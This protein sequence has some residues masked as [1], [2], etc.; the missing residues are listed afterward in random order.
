MSNRVK[1][2]KCQ[3]QDSCKSSLESYQHIQQANICNRIHVSKRKT[4]KLNVAQH[5]KSLGII[6]YTVIRR[7]KKMT[8]GEESQEN[9][10]VGDT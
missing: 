9:T 2:N 4:R 3:T 10:I 1:R 7:I 6:S 5:H 8:C